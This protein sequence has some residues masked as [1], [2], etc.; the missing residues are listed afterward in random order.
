MGDL[1][2][3][4]LGPGGIFRKMAECIEH[5]EGMRVTAVASSSLERAK[6]GAALCGAD[7]AFGSYEA[8]AACEEVDLCYISTL[9][10]AH[11][12]QAILCMEHGKHVLCEKPLAL[13]DSEVREMAACARANGVLLMEAL[14]TRFMPAAVKLRALLA[15][16]AIGE[17][18]HVSS[19]VTFRAPDLPDGRLLNR[20]IGGGAV[21]DVGIYALGAA[22]MVLGDEPSSV[23]GSL[24]VG[25]TGVDIEDAIL[26]TYPNG[27]TAY[28]YSSFNTPSDGALL[29]SGE[30]GK[31]EIGGNF[32]TGELILTRGNE[33]ETYS[34]PEPYHFRPE[35]EHVRDLIRAG[36]TESPVMPLKTSEAI[37]KISTALRHQFGVVYPEEN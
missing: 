29:I 8:L 37:A 35:L 19:R 33:R 34:C 17:V 3:G 28:S 6:D 36:Q 31:I 26:L 32:P 4:I 22:M 1:R 21:L 2:V 14:W 27:A 20:T 11:R 10:N 16:G 7:Y 5:T 30:T 13:S 12:S 18:R 23:Q 9:N 24:T 25:P 15:A